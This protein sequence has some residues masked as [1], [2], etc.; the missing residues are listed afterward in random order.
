MLS[1]RAGSAPSARLLRLTV[2]LSSASSSAAI[3]APSAMNLQPWTFAVLLGRERIGDVCKACKGLVACEP[4][5]NF[6][7]TV[8]SPYARRSPIRLVLSR[9]GPA[10][11]SRQIIRHPACRGLL[12]RSRKPDAGRWESELGT[13]WI[14]FARP[15]LDLPATKT[16]LKL[17]EHYHV[18]APIVLGYPAASPSSHGRRPAEI[19]WL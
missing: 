8:D 11:N 1:G 5:A 15:W 2:P 19:H 4:F 12:P 9:P 16:E 7:R 3:L 14:G 13:C 6:L 10:N 17:P 18:V